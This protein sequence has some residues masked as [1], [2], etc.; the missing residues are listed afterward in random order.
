METVVLFDPGIRS[1]N[2]GDEII[3]RSAEREL[4]IAEYGV[5]TQRNYQFS[6]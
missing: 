4:N 6:H 2:K 5:F 1:L 3:M